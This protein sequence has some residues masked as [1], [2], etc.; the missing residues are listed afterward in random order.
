MIR[1]QLVLIDLAKNLLESADCVDEELREPYYDVLITL[2]NR[3]EFYISYIGFDTELF[4]I[5]TN[6][7]D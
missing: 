5:Y 6:R 1:S 4:E 2:L 3:D 7:K